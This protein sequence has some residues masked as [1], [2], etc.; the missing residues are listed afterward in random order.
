M[1][2]RNEPKLEYNVQQRARAGTAAT[3]RAVVAIYIGYLG[4]KVILGVQDGSSSVPFW[5]GWA[6]GLFLIA[7]ALAFCYY[8]WRRWHIDVEAARIKDMP[9]SGESDEEEPDGE[10]ETQEDAPDLDASSEGI[11][12]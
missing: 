6:I 5:A 8:T 2:E 4:Y 11:E 12:I 10:D 3:F 9:D 1:T 7:A